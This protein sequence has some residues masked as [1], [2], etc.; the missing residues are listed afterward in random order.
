MSWFR[1]EGRMP[2][3][4]KVA[5]LSD[6]AFRLHITAGAWSSDE[7]TD[8]LIPVLVV[9]TLTAAPRGK[10][11]TKILQELVG[12]GVWEQTE[13][14]YQLHDYLQW[15][16][17]AAE[18]E[19][20]RA[21]K[22]TAGQAGGKRSGEQRRSKPEAAASVLLKQTRSKTQALSDPVSVSKP[23]EKPE[24]EARADAPDGRA[25][26]PFMNPAET[27]M[28]DKM[29]EKCLELHG[30]VDSLTANLRLPRAVIIAAVESFCRYRE[31]GAGMGDKRSYW[32]KRI[33]QDIIN[34][35]EQGKLKPIGA[36][37]HDAMNQTVDRD[38]KRQR[39]NALLA[40]AAAGD[41]GSDAQATALS[42]SKPGKAKL[43][44][45]IQNGLVR[46]VRAEPTGLGELLKV[47]GG[48]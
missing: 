29:R 6:A 28:P 18:L 27:V 4:R 2:Q 33:R 23:E 22:A 30:V 39:N 7:G 12:A 41:Y 34:R 46:R 15:N 16:M 14:G 48:P 24:G 5:P 13:R 44:T 40:A 47:P 9:P 37:E 35:A 10:V 32:L 3:H 26:D 19:A 1:I 38:A 25:F 43:L 20:R 8:G 45:E 42:D 11:L 36:V 31:A 17:S 21:A